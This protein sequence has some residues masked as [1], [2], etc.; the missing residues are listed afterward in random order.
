MRPDAR[1]TVA[2]WVGTPAFCFWY[3]T[4]P[5]DTGRHLKVDSIV[6]PNAKDEKLGLTGFDRDCGFQDCLSL[7]SLDL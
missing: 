6:F 7:G 1:L 3:A 4:T 5:P 2:S